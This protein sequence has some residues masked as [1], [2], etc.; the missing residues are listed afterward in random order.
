MVSSTPLEQAL[1]DL[2]KLMDSSLDVIC[3]INKEGR[4]VNVSSA[5]ETIWGYKPEELYGKRYMELVVNEDAEKTEHTAEQIMAGASVTMFENRYIHKNG[6]IVDILWSARW[7]QNDAL[8][9]CTAKDA[10]EKKNLE[11]AFENERQRFYDLFLQA[12]FSMGVLKGPG[13]LFEMVNPS[14]LKLIGRKDII[15]I[16]VEEVMPEMVEQ[17]IIEL[18]DKVYITG[19]AF[20]A[21]EM[22]V[23]LDREENGKL[24]TVFLDFIYQAYK[25]IEG[26]VESIFFFAIDVTERVQSRKQVEESTKLFRQIVETA[27]E[28]IWMIDENNKTSFVNKKTCDILGYSEEE[29]IGKPNFSFKDREDQHIELQEINRRKQDLNETHETRY[30]T[31]SGKSIWT[32]ITNNPI[33]D[34]DG[35]YKGTLAML[36]DITSRKE[37]QLQFQKNFEEREFLIAELTKSIKDLKHFTYITSHNFKAPLSNLVG[38]LQQVDYSTLTNDN[39]EIVK[40]FKA[41][42]QQLDKT[43]NDLVQILIIKNNVHIAISN[44]NVRKLLKDILG[45]SLY[46]I[47][48]AGSEINKDLQ[49]ENIYFNKPYMENVLISLLSNAFNFRSP[50]RPLRI[51]ISTKQKPNGEVLM[52]IKDNGIGIDLTRHQEKIFGLY[53]RFHSNSA[54]VGLGLFIVKSQ[55][56]SLG[57]KIEVESE[58]DAG[59]AF[60]ITFL[61]K[62][63]L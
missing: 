26:N 38:L 5:A 23:N 16:S 19:K 62:G 1:N 12:S 57:G 30:L 46:E 21:N 6:R 36:T 35:K 33:F 13:H 34:E 56:N 49:V 44:I 40:M 54:S 60:K 37:Q 31:K 24:T 32:H 22:R 53:Q 11:K 9:Y 3:S 25:N 29:M 55:I 39:K 63:K 47:E 14:Y 2:K 10:S 41:S 4:F 20:I 42:T 8:M 15:G 61:N 59:T 45:S 51:D 7:D 48:E 27:Q 17:G 28:G 50:E 18:L 52:I 58:V 43:I